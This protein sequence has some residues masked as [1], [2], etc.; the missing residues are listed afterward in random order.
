MGKVIAIR[1]ATTAESNTKDSIVEATKEMLEELVSANDL[2]VKDIISA[3]FTTTK[4]L[5]TQFPAVAA[6]KI[7]WEFVA[8]MCSHEMFIEDAQPM[9]IRVMVHVNSDKDVKLINNVYLNDAI[10][11]R[12]RGFEPKTN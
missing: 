8:L 5:N 7:G 2:D 6:R 9:C 12:K 1:G 4:D 11:L 3:F 10:N